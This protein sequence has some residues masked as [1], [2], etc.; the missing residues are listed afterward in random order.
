MVKTNSFIRFLEEFTA[1]QFA[2]EINWPL[3]AEN[4]ILQEYE[5]NSKKQLKSILDQTI[6]WEN[7]EVWEVWEV[8]AVQ[9]VQSTAQ[10]V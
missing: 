4:R 7:W 5:Q 3:E 2:F 1:W 8:W 6:H 9:A 10:I